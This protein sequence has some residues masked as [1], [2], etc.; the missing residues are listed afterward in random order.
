[1]NSVTVKVDAVRQDVTI[2]GPEIAAKVC[3]EFCYI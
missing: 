2:C 3:R 1:M